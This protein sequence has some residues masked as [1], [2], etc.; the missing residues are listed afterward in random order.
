[1][2]LYFIRHGD[3]IYFPDS[4]TDLGHKQAIAL[5]KKLSTLNFSQIYTSTSER[6][7]LTAKPTC[8]ALGMDYIPLAWCDERYAGEE[9][10]GYDSKNE[11]HFLFTC[12][13]YQKLFVSNEIE[14]LGDKWY[15]H[16]AFENMKC[17]Q[18]MERISTETYR[19]IESLGYK[20]NK[21]ERNYEVARANDDRIALFAHAGFGSVFLSCLLDI[22]YPMFSSRFVMSHS[23]VTVIEFPNNEVSVPRVLTFSNDSHLLKNNLPTT[24]CNLIEL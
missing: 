22:P 8:E 4:L 15:T 9:L 21:E 20:H 13:N 2:L 5:S 10:M 23:T 18:G 12:D 1:M 16:K 24:F 14:R 17:Q 3:P 19:F 6:A 11:K 7:I